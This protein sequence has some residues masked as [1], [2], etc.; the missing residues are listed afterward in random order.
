MRYL[1]TMFDY[2]WGI[3]LINEANSDVAS[4]VG[5]DN[6][7][8]YVNVVLKSETTASCDSD[9]CTGRWLHG[10]VCLYGASTAMWL[11]DNVRR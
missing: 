9:I 3:A 10:Y 4:I 7:C 2:V 5:V 11:Y 6:A 1:V 8:Y